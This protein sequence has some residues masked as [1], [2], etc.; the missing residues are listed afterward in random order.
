MSKKFRCIQCKRFNDIWRP[1]C[2]ICDTRGSLVTNNFLV[3]QKKQAEEEAAREAA[4]RRPKKF[5]DYEPLKGERISTGIPGLDF[6]LGCNRNDPEKKY[7]M[8]RPSVIL[9]GGPAGSG[10]STIVLQA[11]A[12]MHKQEPL[13]TSSE[14][15]LGEIRANATGMGLG[16]AFD[17]VNAQHAEDLG[18]ALDLVHELNP[19]VWFLDSL[20]NISDKAND[21]RDKNMNRLNVAY[22]LKAEAEQYNRTIIAISHL[23]KSSDF[24]GLQELQHAVSVVMLLSNITKTRR[25]LE[26]PSKNRF[27]HPGAQSFFEMTEMGLVPTEAPRVDRDDSGDEDERLDREI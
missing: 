16:D 19:K 17:D 12:S 18:E 27:G 23:N 3:D 11:C 14:Q 8:H 22:R 20:N 15:T 9:F 25:K 2:P 26:C 10:K 7:G 24:A 5:K 21:T 1:F 4:A 13:Y 6:V